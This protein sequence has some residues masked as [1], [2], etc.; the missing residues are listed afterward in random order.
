MAAHTSF[1]FL[2]AKPILFI[3]VTGMI[4]DIAGPDCAQNSRA[5][6]RNWEIMS[7]VE[8]SW[9]FGKIWISSLLPVSDLIRS[10]AFRAQ[11]LVGWDAGRSTPNLYTNSA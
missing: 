1:S 4:V 11:V 3:A 6:E 5:P 8:P 7:V 10:A 2:K 9:L